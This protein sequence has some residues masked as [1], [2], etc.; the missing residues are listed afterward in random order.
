MS[1]A[2]SQIISILHEAH[3]AVFQ[4][5]HNFHTTL[6]TLLLGYNLGLYSFPVRPLLRLLN[7]GPLIQIS[8]VRCRMSDYCSDLWLLIS[9]FW[10][11]F[12]PLSSDLWIH[13]FGV[14]LEPRYI[15]GAEP[16]DQ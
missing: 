12:W 6:Y 5:H 1:E 3:T 14:T 7:L 10:N 15:F 16:L 9:G 11:D 2:G 8:V 4:V 13:S